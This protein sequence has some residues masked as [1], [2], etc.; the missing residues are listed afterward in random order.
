MTVGIGSARVLRKIIVTNNLQEVGRCHVV[1]FG[2]SAWRRCQT[3][4]ACRYE[5]GGGVLINAGWRE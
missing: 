4:R 2:L 1:V 3:Q 5:R